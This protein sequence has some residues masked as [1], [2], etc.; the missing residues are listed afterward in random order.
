MSR[1]LLAGAAAL[2]FTAAPAAAASFTVGLGTDQALISA[3]DF[4]TQLEGLGLDNMRNFAGLTLDGPA[5]VKVELVASEGGSTD[6]LIMP[7]LIHTHGPNINAF[8]APV[9]IG[10]L[11]FNNPATF[12]VQFTSSLSNFL[13]IHSPG[14]EQI[15][16]FLDNAMNGSAATTSVLHIGYDNQIVAPDDDNHDDLII[17]LTATPVPEPAAWALMIA[18][19][20]LA[21]A[22]AR[23]RRARFAYA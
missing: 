21:G 20:G 22:A 14:G 19:F 3:N 12:N 1:Y 5:R 16:Y 13:T 15:G 2:A 7:G 10:M 17:R 9:L 23:R 6:R 8:A 11:T 18:G 4:K